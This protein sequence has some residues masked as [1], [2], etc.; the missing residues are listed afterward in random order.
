MAYLK[1]SN[2]TSVISNPRDSAERP[3]LCSNICKLTGNVRR[4]AC[5]KAS[6][7]LDALSSD[8]CSACLPTSASL[9]S[10]GNMALNSSAD[11]LGAAGSATA[12]I[13][14]PSSCKNGSKSH[15]FSLF[16]IDSKYYI[17]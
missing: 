4:T 17:I 11:F 1:S 9:I 3:V 6:T 12:A 13:S 16:E 15:L 2:E 5:P 8:H 7:V 10:A 14:L